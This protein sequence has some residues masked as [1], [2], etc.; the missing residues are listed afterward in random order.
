MVDLSV[1]VGSIE[2]PNPIILASGTCGYGV[3]LARFGDI[4]VFGAIA[5]K[6][7]SLEPHEGNPAPRV[8][9]T[10]GG[11]VN[12]IGLENI[13]IERFLT[14]KLPELYELNPRVIVNFWGRTIEEC[15]EVAAALGSEPRVVAAE[16]NISCP[17]IQRGGVHFVADGDHLGDLISGCKSRLG[18]KPLVVKLPPNVLDIADLARFVDDKG[19]DVVSAIN[20]IPAMVIDW[21]TGKPLLGARFGGL[22][23]PC[24][25]PVAV[26]AVYEIAHRTGIPV[27]GVGGIF[28]AEDVLEFLAAGAG[29][30]E[31]GTLVMVDPERAFGLPT[32]LAGALAS[33][34]V[35]SVGEYLSACGS[36]DR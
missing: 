25:K 22:S 36:D 33:I 26:K 3:E 11:I 9:E 30:V 18:D 2:L 35:S 8:V 17:N 32:E 27:I 29:A 5:V 7:L 21:R 4:S 14:E 16:L 34:G 31:I 23:G 28:C 12:S 24:I 1:R 15:F 6:G 20:T 19:A 10:T 13:G